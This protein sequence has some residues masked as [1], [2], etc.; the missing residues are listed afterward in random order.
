M[1]IINDVA[2]Q[3]LFALHAI[4]GHSWILDWP[5]IYLVV[6]Y[7]YHLLLM[8]QKPWRVNKY[9]LFTLFLIANFM[10]PYLLKFDGS[11]WGMLSGIL[12]SKK[13]QSVVLLAWKRALE[14]L[15]G[16]IWIFG[17]AFSSIWARVM[18]MKNQS[19][20]IYKIRA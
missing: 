11:L 9:S 20:L 13:N 10:N 2:Q 1:I 17:T 7:Y 8:E 12:V 15:C 5:V 18:I 3:N 19:P 16:F 14:L 6:I 4:Q